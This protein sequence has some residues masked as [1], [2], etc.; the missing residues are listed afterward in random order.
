MW[1]PISATWSWGTHLMIQ[2]T[3]WTFYLRS[4]PSG[5]LERIIGQP[6]EVSGIG[7]KASFTLNYINLDLTTQAHVSSHSI[8]SH[9]RPGLLIICCLEELRST[10]IRLSFPRIT[11]ALKPPGKARE[12][13]SMPLNVRSRD[14]SHF[15]EAVF[16]ENLVEDGELVAAW[17]RG[18][19]LSA[20]GGPRGAKVWSLTR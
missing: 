7:G 19:P 4:R 20:W 3:C 13:M 10:S 2:A 17:P 6:I 9:W 5:F 14:E 1:Q 8:S 16:F 18:V 15:L 11:N 12:S